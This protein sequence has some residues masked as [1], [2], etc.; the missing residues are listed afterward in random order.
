MSLIASILVNAVV[1]AAPTTPLPWYHMDDYPL[2]AFDR[3]WRGVAVFELLVGTDGRPTKCS[4]TQSTGFAEFDKQTCYIAMN[5]ARFTPAHGPDGAPVFGSYRSMVIWHRPDQPT[6]QVE[7]GPDLHLTVSALPPGTRQPA[8]VKLA[9]FIDAR[10]QP[11]SCTVLPESEVQPAPLVDAA[12]QQVFARLAKP[13]G[14]S[15]QGVPTVRTEAVL[16]TTGNLPK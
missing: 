7:P 2:K 1:A 8:A 9:Y 11:S 13:A 16:F 12:C 14:E 10:G 15:E 3:R 5:R 6:I 4:V